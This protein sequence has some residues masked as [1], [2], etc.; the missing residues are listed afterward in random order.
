MRPERQENLNFAN[1]DYHV[2]PRLEVGLLNQAFDAF[3]E[4]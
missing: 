2:R 4:A 1:F 3:I